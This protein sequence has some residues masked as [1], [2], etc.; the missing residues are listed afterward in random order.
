MN[1]LTLLALLGGPLLPTPPAAPP[2][3]ARPMPATGR[4]RRIG[5]S[6]RSHA[7]LRQRRSGNAPEP[8]VTV[9]PRFADDAAETML[10]ALP[11]AAMLFVAPTSELVRANAAA[12]RLVG[13]V[14]STGSGFRAAQVRLGRKDGA[15]LVPLQHPV[16]RAFA[17]EAVSAVELRLLVSDGRQIPVEV[18]ARALPWAGRTAV[19]LTLTDSSERKA[20]ERLADE[21]SAMIAHDLR[22]PLH[23]LLLQVDALTM[24]A[25]GGAAAVSLEALDRMRRNGKRLNRMIDDLLDRGRIETGR[26]NLQPEP[27]SLDEVVTSLAGQLA[28][29]MGDRILVVDVTAGLPEAHV[30][31]MRV[32]QV[33]TNLIE[34][35]AKYSPPE[36]PIHVAVEPF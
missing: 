8:R 36:C 4:Q 22:T 13:R 24:R 35:A 26:L 16:A 33:L 9:S 2:Q 32:Q 11:H 29:G 27:A 31:V 30:D 18:S 6:P 20:R 12:E 7:R 5:A 23:S 10:E 14:L 21:L 15:E 1:A 17:G 3:R 28:A 25:S 34:N 19:L